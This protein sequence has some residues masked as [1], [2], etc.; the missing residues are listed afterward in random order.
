MGL[1]RSKA[2]F[3]SVLTALTFVAGTAT[4]VAISK[5]SNKGGNSQFDATTACLARGYF[6]SVFLYDIYWWINGIFKN[7]CKSR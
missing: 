3:L 7:L 1:E 2:V 4:G 6:Q 5:I